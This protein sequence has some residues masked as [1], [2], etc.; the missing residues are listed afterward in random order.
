MELLDPR[1][2]GR[3]PLPLCGQLSLSN[4][5]YYRIE[6]Q[7]LSLKG[8]RINPHPLIQGIGRRCILTLFA[9]GRQARAL[10]F[11]GR[12]IYADGAGCGIEFQA[13]DRQ[14]FR[15]FEALMEERAPEPA[16]FR[17]EVEQGLIPTLENWRLWYNHAENQAQIPSRPAGV[18]P[19]PQG[20][21]GG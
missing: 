8:A 7:N 14:D 16:Q 15:W 4:N 11:A 10:T 17:Q 1:R 13:V 9:T 5:E 21:Q 2:N 6:T 19:A 12:I 3:I 20:P 18:C